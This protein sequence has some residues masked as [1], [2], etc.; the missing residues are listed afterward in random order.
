MGTD[1]I[2]I[3]G[4]PLKRQSFAI[5]TSGNGLSGIPGLIGVGLPALEST[6]VN[7]GFFSNRHTYSNVPL[8][9]FEQGHI[10]TP[11]YSLS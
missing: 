3:S 6:N 10:N 8:S 7:G 4:A 1:D 9:L 2:T 11:T 5:V